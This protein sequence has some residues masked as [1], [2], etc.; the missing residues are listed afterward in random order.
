M[1]FLWEIIIRSPV[2]PHGWLK[3]VPRHPEWALLGIIAPA[4]IKASCIRAQQ[5]PS[6][7]SF[8]QA[9]RKGRSVI[10]FPKNVRSPSAL[11]CFMNLWGVYFSHSDC[12]SSEL[13]ESGH[14][15]FNVRQVRL[16]KC[17]V[18]WLGT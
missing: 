6:M 1:I 4:I 14:G 13:V 3:Q 9:C 2:H 10:T 15:S 7:I 16:I 11:S 12:E 8:V 5:S 18:K 17:C